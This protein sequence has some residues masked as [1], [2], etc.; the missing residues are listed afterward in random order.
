MPKLI[1]EA[2][3]IRKSY[4]IGKSELS[5][6]KDINLNIEA[7]EIV[8]VVGA[9]GAGKS[10]LLHI[11]GTLDRPTSGTVRYDGTDL[12]KLSDERIA[13]FRSLQIGFVFQFHHL[14]PEFTAIEN[15]AM[16]AMIAGK[17]LF[18]V[19][20]L[21][22]E[23]LSEVGLIDR[24]EHRPSELSGGEQQRVAVARALINTPK[25]ILADEPSGN[26]DSR[27]AESLH[28]LMLDLCRKHQTTFVIATHNDH[29]TNLANRVVKI[30][31][32]ILA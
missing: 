14:L 30:Q 22:S 21:A 32:G 9:S 20:K 1:I 10:T 19:K 6:L 4:F 15:V 28:E 23:L 8:A 25:V 27:N 3:Q 2:S 29:L 7:G 17:K 12:F 13:K 5:V 24:A 16:P 26:L 18:E 11:L 31:D